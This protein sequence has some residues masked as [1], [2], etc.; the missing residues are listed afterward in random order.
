MVSTHRA[1]ETR[2]RDAK[3]C[4]HALQDGR[5]GR[6]GAQ[7]DPTPKYRVW[8]AGQALP[9]GSPI[10]RL[11]ADFTTAGAS[12]DMLRGTEPPEKL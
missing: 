7:D 11:P 10:S 1:R 8:G 6:R 12:A 3:L 5:G 2:L 4:R 9:R